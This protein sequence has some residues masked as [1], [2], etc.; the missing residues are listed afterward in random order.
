[1]SLNKSFKRMSAAALLSCLCLAAAGKAKAEQVVVL[2]QT[3]L[4]YSE[5]ESYMLKLANC[6]RQPR[7][8]AVKL[9]ALRGNADLK[10]VTLVY[11]NGEVDR[12]PI[13][14]RLNQGNET[15]WIAVQGNKR[16]ISRI[17]IVGDTSNSSANRALLKVLGLTP[18]NYVG[19][20]PG[21]STSSFYQGWLLGETPLAFAENDRE[22]LNL[23]NC[24]RQPRYQAVKVRAVRG[25]AD[26]K[27]LNLRFG[28]GTTQ[29]LYVRENLNQGSET[30]W[31]DLQGN[32]RCIT[33]IT[34]VGD[35][36]DRSQNRALL[37][38]FGR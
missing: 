8:T 20:K 18:N 11:G 7:Y 34:V 33:R 38:V 15:G 12:L 22:V 26:I 31:I 27:Q 9:Q 23:G 28:D 37:Q 21:S 16:C 1:M 25:S 13:V 17:T 19:P 32:K 14:K 5:N 30:R 24:D 10:Q 3:T 2:G 4:A 6:D 35:T 29:Q 36:D